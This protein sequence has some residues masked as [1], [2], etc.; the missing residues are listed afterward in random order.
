MKEKIEKGDLIYY[1]WL[2][3]GAVIGGYVG[4]VLD[5]KDL[6]VCDDDLFERSDNGASIHQI[7]DCDI[8]KK[9]GITTSKALQEKRDIWE[10]LEQIWEK[11]N[12]GSS[13]LFEQFE[14]QALKKL[15]GVEE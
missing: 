15:C 14:Y 11:K 6:L 1:H 7:V 4:E 3:D 8:K 5:D 13:F 10:F 9:I 12:I 2:I